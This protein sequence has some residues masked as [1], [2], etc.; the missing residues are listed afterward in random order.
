MLP[1]PLRDRGN[2]DARSR[3]IQCQLSV[4]LRGYEA[5]TAPA[6]AEILPTKQMPIFVSSLL[7]RLQN[8]E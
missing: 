7:S 4:N 5:T 3:Y 8:Y 1:W 2:D 6:L